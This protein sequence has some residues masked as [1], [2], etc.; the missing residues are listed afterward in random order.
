MLSTKIDPITVATAFASALFGAEL[1]QFVGPYAVILLASTMGAGWALGRSPAMPSKW[2]ALWYFGR[3]NTLALLITVPLAMLV[4]WSFSMD[5][6]SWLLAP[7]A[8]FVGGVGND[9]PQVGAWI[10]KRL[11][12]LIER[13]TDTSDSKHS[14]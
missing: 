5:D 6:P 14:E 9:W 2:E 13:R 7:I 3:L 12:R 1:A 11:G 8:I 4:A 10:V